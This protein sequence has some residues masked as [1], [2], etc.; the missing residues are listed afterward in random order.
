MSILS[1]PGLRIY[2]RTLDDTRVVISEFPERVMALVLDQ[3]PIINPYFIGFCSTEQVCI[4]CTLVK[5]DYKYG[6]KELCSTAV[7]VSFISKMI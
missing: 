3:K 7:V 2:T 4:E 5:D 6:E 1:I